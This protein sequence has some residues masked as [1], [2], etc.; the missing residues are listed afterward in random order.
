LV[1]DVHAA[2]LNGSDMLQRVGLYPPPPGIPAEIPGLE[3]AGEVVAIGRGVERFGVGDRVM[4]LVAGA[5]QAERAVVH[6]RVALPVPDPLSWAEAGG[7]PEV[8]VTAHDA[9]FT[10]CELSPGERVLIHGGAGGVGIAGVQL[11]AVAGARVTATVRNRGLRD[12]VATIGRRAGWTQV[13]APDD[14]V[15]RG[16]FDVVLELIGAPNLDGDLRA[17]ATWGRIVVIGVGAGASAEI[18]LL[19]LMAA[20]GRI[21]ASTLRPRPLEE[22]ARAV[23]LVEAHVLPFF[24]DDSEDARLQVPVAATYPMSE[25]EA[26]YDRFAAGG[27]LGKIVLTRD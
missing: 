21:H 15:E 6:E 5:G 2:G 23:R 10:Q 19:A 18:N 4:A 11:A 25:A 22:K 8:F 3:F 9:L 12:A 14:F 16:P 17:L 27:K 24:G 20:R 26:A 13:V 1:V 7:F